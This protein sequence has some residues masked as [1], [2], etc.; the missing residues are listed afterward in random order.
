M[1]LSCTKPQLIWYLLYNERTIRYLN[2]VEDW[3]LGVGPCFDLRYSV[4]GNLSSLQVRV[5]RTSAIFL[6]SMIPSRSATRPSVYQHLWACALQQGESIFDVEVT[7]GQIQQANM[8]RD[9]KGYMCEGRPSLTTCSL[10]PTH[11]PLPCRPGCFLDC[12]G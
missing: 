1:L 4:L 11:R 8:D 10:L 3:R 9:N 2:P 12:G 5:G 7:Q 6:Q